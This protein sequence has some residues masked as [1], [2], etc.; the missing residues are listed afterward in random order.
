VVKHAHGHER[1]ALA[2]RA[3]GPSPPA[4]K[5]TALSIEHPQVRRAI[6]ERVRHPPKQKQL[7]L[8]HKQGRMVM[9]GRGQDHEHQLEPD[10]VGHLQDVDVVDRVG[11]D[12]AETEV[13]GPE[14]T[15][16]A[17]SVVLTV[18]R[19]RAGCF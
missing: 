4:I 8:R 11:P 18:G 7:K 5:L 12:L 9:P 2:L 17:G 19:L 16:V 13:D 14:K 3:D 1:I 15:I 10:Q 6:I